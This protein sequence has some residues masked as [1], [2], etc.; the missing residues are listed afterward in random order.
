MTAGDGSGGWIA[1]LSDTIG[2]PEAALR[3]LLTLLAGK[4][5]FFASQF[6]FL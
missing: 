1:S 3:L 5:A 2:A 6:V 4:H